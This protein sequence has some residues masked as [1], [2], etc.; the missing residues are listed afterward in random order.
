MST[1]LSVYGGGLLTLVA[2]KYGIAEH[3]PSVPY[4]TFTDDFLMCQICLVF[5]FIMEC[6]VAFRSQ[7][8]LARK[9]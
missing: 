9:S 3:L 6:L 7:L 5:L 2:F 8:S 4:S 1:R